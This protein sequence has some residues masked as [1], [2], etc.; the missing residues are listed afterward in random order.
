MVRPWLSSKLL[1]QE[2]QLCSWKPPVKLGRGPL[3]KDQRR[4]VN[5]K[6]R[7]EKKVRPR[8]LRFM[9]HS[10]SQWCGHEKAWGMQS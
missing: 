3:E 8:Y 1:W 7:N 2:L 9:Q 4:A 5:E 6:K 10:L